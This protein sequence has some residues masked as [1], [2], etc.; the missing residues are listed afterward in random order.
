[1]T[2]GENFC[3]QNGAGSQAI[4]QGEK[5][6]ERDSIN[7]TISMRTDFLVGTDIQGSSGLISLQAAYRERNRKGMAN[8]TAA[9]RFSGL[10]KE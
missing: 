10:R 8:L 5:P 4:S 3:P 6:S 1:M 9:L 7:A 2:E